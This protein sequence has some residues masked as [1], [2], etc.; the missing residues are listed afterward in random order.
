MK[1]RL[2]ELGGKIYIKQENRGKFTATMKRTGK[3]AEE[4]YHSSNPL[5][6]KRAVFAL[7]ARK[8]NK[9]EGGV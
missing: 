5:T 1:R 2:C 9:A 6:S 4:L 3:T 8:W 7:N